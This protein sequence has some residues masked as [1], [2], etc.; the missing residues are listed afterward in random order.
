[1]GVGSKS[2][3]GT[4][5]I[6]WPNH[7]I[8]WKV[9]CTQSLE[10]KEALLDLRSPKMSQHWPHHW[11]LLL[12]ITL[13]PCKSLKS[14]L[15]VFVSRPYQAYIQVSIYIYSHD[16]YKINVNRI[17]REYRAYR[18]LL[19]R[20][21]LMTLFTRSKQDKTREKKMDIG[22]FDI[23]IAES[24]HRTA[25]YHY[26]YSWHWLVFWVNRQQPSTAGGIF[27]SSKNRSLHYILIIMSW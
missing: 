14:N 10:H 15:L 19:T 2:T 13:Q 27:S 11:I 24:S 21:F 25:H 7:Q 4:P 23:I 9:I 1:M 18:R 8:F 5:S 12:W 6:L 26:E 16:Q 20:F 17:Q 22:T 3:H